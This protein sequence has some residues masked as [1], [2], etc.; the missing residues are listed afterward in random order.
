M[1]KL[2]HLLF[3]GIV[4]TVGYGCESHHKDDSMQEEEEKVQT[5]SIQN[6]TQKPHVE[7]EHGGNS[8]NR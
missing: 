3:L 6:D 4:M 7:N 1:K 8:G 2:I 5:E